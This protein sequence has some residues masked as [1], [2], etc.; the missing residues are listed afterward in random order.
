MSKT[1]SC[2]VAGFVIRISSFLRISS[3][4]IRI[5]EQW[6]MESVEVGVGRDR[7]VVGEQEGLRHGLGELLSI[8]RLPNQL[9]LARIGQVTSFQQDRWP[10]LG[11]QYTHEP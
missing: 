2:A 7:D 11:P 9:S 10:V 5:W 4:V 6:F 8:L 1:L 3:F